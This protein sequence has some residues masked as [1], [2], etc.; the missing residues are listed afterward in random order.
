MK[1]ICF[2]LL[3]LSACGEPK[4]E[5][6][7]IIKPADSKYIYECRRT[8]NDKKDIWEYKYI[9]TLNIVK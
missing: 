8:W 3:F 1:A 7:S 6:G 2:A 5:I 4:C 9:P